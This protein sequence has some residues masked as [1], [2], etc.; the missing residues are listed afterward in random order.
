M[1]HLKR[2]RPSQHDRRL[3]LLVQPG[4]HRGDTAS[5][6]LELLRPLVR[7]ALTTGSV[8]F[9]GEGT[10]LDHLALNKNL[11]NSERR[12]FSTPMLVWGKLT[13]FGCIWKSNVSLELELA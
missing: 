1:K 2:N 8:Y 6:T 9:G 11:V 4:D 5:H 3:S 7:L 12:G 10:S 13:V